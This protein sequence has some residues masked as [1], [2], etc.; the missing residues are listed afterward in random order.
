MIMGIN[1]LE[2]LYH[3]NNCLLIY[4]LFKEDLELVFLTQLPT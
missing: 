2:S 1:K 4:G 3:I